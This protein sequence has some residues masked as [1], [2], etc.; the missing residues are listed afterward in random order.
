MSAKQRSNPECSAGNKGTNE[1]LIFHLKMIHCAKSHLLERL[2]DFLGL[3]HL[4]ELQSA[5]EETI[6]TIE[7][8][9]KYMEEMS[10]I[11]NFEYSGEYCA[12]IA[13]YA[14]LCYEQIHFVI[15]DTEL[16]DYAILYYMQNIAGME[17]TSFQSLL[18]AASRISDKR[19]INLIKDN[20]EAAK[21]ER[22]LFEHTFKRYVHHL[23]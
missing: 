20:F 23:P 8:Q 17:T 21:S 13:P 11:L 2:P 10:V 15:D 5:I 9:L 4:R 7:L 3:S 22:Q 1:F 12:E 16:C 18:R 19:L 14:E 6:R